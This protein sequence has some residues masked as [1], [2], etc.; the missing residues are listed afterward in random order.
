[1]RT[2]HETEALR[3]SDPIPKSM[4]PAAKTSR[5]LKLIHKSSPHSSEETSGVTVNGNSNGDASGDWASSY[6]VDLGFTADEEIRGPEQL[7]HHLRRELIWGEEELEI[8]K[9]QAD[10]LEIIRRKEWM[11]KEVLMDQVV[12]NEMSYFERRAAVLEGQAKLPSTEEIRAAAAFTGTSQPLE[13]SQEPPVSL[14]P[15]TAPLLNH[16]TLI[17]SQ[18]LEDRTEAAAV[19][20]SMRQT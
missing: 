10:E 1:M 20:A 2:V 14:P 17:K 5:R 12:K 13:S 4:Q 7:Y 9:R 11:E 8:L 15:P 3:P 16:R 18:P 6:P 19:L